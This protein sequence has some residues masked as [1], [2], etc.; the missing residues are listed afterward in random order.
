MMNKR[1]SELAWKITDEYERNV[2]K[3]KEAFHQD[4]PESSLE[5]L[6]AIN[7]EALAQAIANAIN[8]VALWPIR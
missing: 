8:N 7:R 4:I 6:L 2:F 1:A 5:Q 3:T